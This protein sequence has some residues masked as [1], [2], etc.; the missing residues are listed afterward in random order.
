MLKLPHYL[1]RFIWQFCTA[2][3]IVVAIA[4]CSNN[5]STKPNSALTENCRVI[6]HAM[7]ETCVPINPQRIVVSF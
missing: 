6:Q 4:A 2:I 1:Y 3:L 7:G 5:T